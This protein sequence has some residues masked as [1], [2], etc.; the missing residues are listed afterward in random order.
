M[1]YFI[2][3][4]EVK[5]DPDI[6]L[7]NTTKMKLACSTWLSFIKQN[8]FNKGRQKTL[9][10]ILINNVVAKQWALLIS[11]IKHATRGNFVWETRR[12][13]RLYLLICICVTDHWCEQLIATSMSLGNRLFYFVALYDDWVD[14][15]RWLIDHENVDDVQT[16]VWIED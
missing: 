5:F 13:N 1:S 7:K 14:Q 2:I 3:N 16:I 6:L 10:L 12:S 8:F 15:I 9:D 4:Y 11:I